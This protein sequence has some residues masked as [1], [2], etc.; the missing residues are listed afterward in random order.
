MSSTEKFVSVASRRRLR[1]HHTDLSSYMLLSRYNNTLAAY[2]QYVSSLYAADT[3]ITD[4]IRTLL[5]TFEELN[6]P[7]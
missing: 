3:G 5:Q 6:R 7:S 4:F 2:I 1:Q